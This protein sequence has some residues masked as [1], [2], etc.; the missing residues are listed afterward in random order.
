MEKNHRLTLFLW[1][2]GLFPKAVAYFLLVK[3]LVDS[4]AQMYEGR[5]N[6]ARLEIRVI[7]FNGTGFEIDDP[8]DPKPPGKSSPCL[9]VTNE[10]DPNDI[11]WVHESTSI[12][13]FL[14]ET[15][16]Q[17]THMISN[18]ALERANTNDCL[19]S[20]YSGISDCNYYIKNA[21]GV[22]TI[23][24]GIQNEDRSLPIASHAKKCMTQ[25]FKKVQ[26]WAAQSLQASGWLTV[27][28]E[29]PGLIDVCLAAA[30]RYME[31]SYSLNILEDPM[32][33][34]LCEWYTRFKLLPWWEEYEERGRHPKE[35]SYPASCREI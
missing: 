26:E 29:G 6:D 30:V 10:N 7:S 32:L 33:E 35:M 23:W 15:F 19:A 3:G 9:R 24:S 4:P 2:E 13:R 21:A 22:T 34:P 27:G 31:L 1:L 20:V 12:V 14:E 16:P 11:T 17:K 8:Q 5:T 25:S 28:V 18:K